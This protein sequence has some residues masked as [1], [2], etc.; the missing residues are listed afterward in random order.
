MVLTP[1]KS[2]ERSEE[3]HNAPLPYRDFSRDDW[4]RNHLSLQYTERFFNLAD[5]RGIPVFWLM[6]PMPRKPQARRDALGL[7]DYFTRLAGAVQARHPGV[8]VIDARR[9]RYDEDVFH[10]N[11]HL[12]K[13]GGTTWSL[14]V[15]EVLVG[16]FIDPAATARHVALPDYRDVPS[17]AP[18]EDFSQTLIGLKDE[19][20]R[21]R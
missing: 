5:E 9:A 3:A 17:D 19:W 6:P 12:A 2:P 15:A 20:R 16:H 4:S 18:I 13:Q 7:D 11:V 8:V 14:D 10:D 21:R 1:G